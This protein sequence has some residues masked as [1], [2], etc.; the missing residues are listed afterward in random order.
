MNTPTTHNNIVVGQIP[1]RRSVWGPPLATAASDLGMYYGR[2]SASRSLVRKSPQLDP[3]KND[4][5]Y[6]HHP[7][8]FFGPPLD[9]EKLWL[10]TNRP[11]SFVI[12]NKDNNPKNTALTIINPNK[13][14]SGQQTPAQQ[15]PANDSLTLSSPEPDDWMV[16]PDYVSWGGFEQTSPPGDDDWNEVPNLQP[17]SSK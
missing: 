14:D 5:G 8:G 3:L 6:D 2:L 13:T 12:H 4:A 1:R 15:T 16:V 11:A 9:K 7:A 10:P 17:N